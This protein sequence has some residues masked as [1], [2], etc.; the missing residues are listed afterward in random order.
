MKAY[1]WGI[2]KQDLEKAGYTDGCPGCKALIL[3][4]HGQ[5]SEQ[6]RKRIEEYLRT[7]GNADDIGRLERSE[8]RAAAAMDRLAERA[9]RIATVQARLREHSCQGEGSEQTADEPNI[10]C[11]RRRGRGQETEG[12][13][14]RWATW[15]HSR[16][17]STSGK[18]RSS[19]SAD[20]KAA[21][22]QS[23][24]SAEPAQAQ[25]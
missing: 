4:K 3:E 6:C 18:A 21:R 2:R 15:G 1:R 22:R 20:G 16:E 8:A 13:R 10:H 12:Q 7:S 23:G 25:E 11:A 14:G 24:F 17:A 5:H 19:Q 9:D